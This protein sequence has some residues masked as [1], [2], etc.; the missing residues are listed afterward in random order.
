MSS[1]PCNVVLLPDAELAESAIRCSADLQDLGVHF[2]LAVGAF[3]P[4]VTVYMLQL[5][6]NDLDSV[7]HLLEGITNGTPKF[8]LEAARYWQAQ[9]FFDVEYTKTQQVSQLQDEVVA[10]LN[11]VRDGMCQKD[12]ARMAEAE[13]QRLENYKLYGWDCIGELYRPHM[14]ITR[15]TDE[16]D[17][18]KL[19][20]PDVANFSGSFSKL[21]LFEMGDNGTCVRKIAEFQLGVA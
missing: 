2:A 7:Q 20:L 19:N 18:T 11:P 6:S 16:Q 17:I 9:Q 1:V 12:V 15:F 3:Y 13:G 21:G 5:R 4:H 10:A 8:E 14:T